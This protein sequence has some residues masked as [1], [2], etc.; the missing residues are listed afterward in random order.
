MIFFR[1]KKDNVCEELT[2]QITA[3]IRDTKYKLLSVEYDPLSFG[4]AAVELTS[5]N[6]NIR[7]VYDR[8]DIYRDKKITGQNRWSARELIYDHSMPCNETY[9]LLIKA[10]DEYV[11]TPP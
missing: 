3:L 2:K 10:V 1:K 11:T 5:D 8:G 9:E 4:N 7:F 6:L